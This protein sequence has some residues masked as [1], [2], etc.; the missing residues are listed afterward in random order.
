MSKKIEHFLASDGAVVL[1]V[2]M[3]PNQ[4]LVPKLSV[5]ITPDGTFLSPPLE[6]LSP[7]IPLDQLRKYLLAP[8]HPNSE[9]I[10]RP[11]SKAN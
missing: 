2:F 3:D 4:L 9:A 5:S 11:S 6:D 10:E 7:L 8:V 1:E